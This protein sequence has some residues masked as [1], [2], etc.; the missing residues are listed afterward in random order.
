VKKSRAQE[1]LEQLGSDLESKRAQVIELAEALAQAYAEG[2]DGGKIARRIGELRAEIE[3]AEAAIPVLER[4][5]AEERAGLLAE[6]VTTLEM[7]MERLEGEKAQFIAQRRG[8]LE[9][10]QEEAD[11]I[12]VQV[13]CLNNELQEMRSWVVRKRRDLSNLQKQRAGEL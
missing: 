4:R 2:N 7:A 1:T 8:I 9:A 12:A 11:G 13:S 5:A 3:A 6:E 10:A